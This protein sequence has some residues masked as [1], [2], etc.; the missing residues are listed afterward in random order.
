MYLDAAVS[1]M[2]DIIITGNKK[3]FPEPEYAGTKILSPREFLELMHA[4]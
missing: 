2:A 3:H 1:S 4:E